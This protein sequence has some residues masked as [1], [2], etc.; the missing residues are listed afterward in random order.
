MVEGLVSMHSSIL[1]QIW[2]LLKGLASGRL[3]QNWLLN[4]L[5]SWYSLLTSSV[6]LRDSQ[7]SLVPRLSWYIARERRERRYI[8]GGSGDDT[9]ANWIYQGLLRSSSGIANWIQ[10]IQIKVD[11]LRLLIHQLRQGKHSQSSWQRSSL[12][13][14]P[15]SVQNSI[16]ISV[17]SPVHE[18]SPESRVQ[19]LHQ[20]V[21]YVCMWDVCSDTSST[22]P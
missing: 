3:V 7:L 12:G 22:W 14:A 6:Y 10:V 16:Q 13:P 15:F 1:T 19:L 20:A 11:L 21:Q 4:A 8:S 18:S 9:I 5:A 17:H 2:G